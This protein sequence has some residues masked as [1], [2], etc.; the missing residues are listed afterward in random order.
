AKANKI[1]P[2]QLGGGT[3]PEDGAPSPQAPSQGNSGPAST[4]AMPLAL[5]SLREG[6]REDTQLIVDLLGVRMERL[7]RE[8]VDSQARSLAESLAARPPEPARVRDDLGQGPATVPAAAFARRPH[9]PP[10]PPITPGPLTDLDGDLDPEPRAKVGKEDVKVRRKVTNRVLQAT[11]VKSVVMDVFATASDSMSTLHNFAQQDWLDD[12]IR[13]GVNR[14]LERCAGALPERCAERSRRWECSAAT[15][16]TLAGA[17]IS[18]PARIGRSR[19][20][21]GFNAACVLMISLNAVL[22]TFST[23]YEMQH[24]GSSTDWMVY[25]EYVFICWYALELVMKIAA[26]GK[27]FF[28][29]PDWTWNI[30]DFVLVAF[31]AV[32]LTVMTGAVNVAF[33]RSLRLFKI[34]KIF[35][36]FRFLEFLKDVKVMVYCM[37]HSLVAVFWAL[38]LIV[39]LLYMFTIIIMQGVILSMEDFDE[40][41]ADAADPSATFSSVTETM[42]QRSRE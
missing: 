18:G 28:A 10:V 15:A 27:Y 8:L 14:L 21:S 41:A 40:T 3:A 11:E 1:T 9:Q 4:A 16:P 35:R 36:L 34:S 7:Q 33:I 20:A 2:R 17:Q 25:G 5:E 19:M 37:V 30:F 38:V 24:L 12:R 29:G 39:F 26:Q 13:V 32:Q 42:V 6:L 31:S 23:D 22:I